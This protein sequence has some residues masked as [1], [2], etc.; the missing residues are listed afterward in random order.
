MEMVFALNANSMS[1]I[2]YSNSN[3]TIVEW[4]EAET[5]AIFYATGASLWS[6]NSSIW[7]IL[8]SSSCIKMT[9]VLECF[10]VYCDSKLAST[11]HVHFNLS[12]TSDQKWSCVDLNS[13]PVNPLQ[14]TVQKLYSEQA[15][16]SL[17]RKSEG[18]K[19]TQTATGDVLGLSSVYMSQWPGVTCLV[20]G[21]V[22][23]KPV[24]K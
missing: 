6:G 23:H 9:S 7:N 21:P 13:L 2:K 10:T 15:V 19:C 1:I 14:C 16:K 3:D 11:Y 12:F 8:M 4:V 22:I 17:S 5:A 24:C 18:K 20:L